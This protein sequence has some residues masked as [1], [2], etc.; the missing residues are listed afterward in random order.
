MFLGYFFCISTVHTKVSKI[1]GVAFVLKAN[2]E[3]RKRRSRE[4]C[5]VILTQ[6]E[7]HDSSICVH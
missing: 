4:T 1:T 2:N 3:D 5:E 6:P 7:A